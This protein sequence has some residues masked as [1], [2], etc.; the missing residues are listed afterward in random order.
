MSQET[1]AATA[2]PTSSFRQISRHMLKAQADTQES[3]KKGL[4]RA[5]R[6]STA[7]LPEAFFH[8]PILD[9]PEGAE[10]K[11]F[12]DLDHDVDIHYYVSKAKVERG[13]VVACTGLKEPISLSKERIQQL[14]DQGLS[15]ICLRL[16]NTGTDS[17]IIELYESYQ[18]F[19]YLD[20]RSPVHQLFPDV[21]KFIEAHSTGGQ[22]AIILATHPETA[23]GMKQYKTIYADAPFLDTPLSSEFDP[24]WRQV[25]YNIYANIAGDR[26]PENE[27][28][29]A[30]YLVLG[31]IK[32]GKIKVPENASN[33]LMFAAQETKRRLEIIKNG[34]NAWEKEIEGE[35]KGLESRHRL[36]TSN[37]SLE[38][39]TRPRGHKRFLEKNGVPDHTPIVIYADPND[40]FSSFLAAEYWANLIGANLVPSSGIH[41]QLNKD[42]KAFAN[43]LG[44]MEQFLPAWPEP[45]VEA[46][47]TPKEKPEE[48]KGWHHTFYNF[49]VNAP[50]QIFA[51]AASIFKWPGKKEEQIASPPAPPENINADTHTPAP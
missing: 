21:V 34:G 40:D 37:Q 12:R 24:L 7:K 22:G 18:K 48:A 4:L 27:P 10:E 19:F 3:F 11:S 41:N 45:E 51:R 44:D 38:L 14:N 36:P 42:D 43:F 33:E 15:Y 20:P 30:F 13:V 9:L 50:A 29:G 16:P 1:T 46:K 6:K 26:L 2:R 17:N 39:R 25:A 47:I 8:Y 31:D 32:K 28:F 49:S 35:A 5:F 23:E